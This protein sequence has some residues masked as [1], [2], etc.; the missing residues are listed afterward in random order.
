MITPIIRVITSIQ[1]MITQKKI[2]GIVLLICVISLASCEKNISVEVPH[3]ESAIVVEGYIEAG[4]HPFILLSNTLPFF[5]TISTNLLDQLQ[6][7]IQGATVTINNGNVIDTLQQVPGFGA[8]FSLNMV[9]EAGKTYALRIETDGKILT[10]STFIP[11]AVHLDSVWFKVDGNRDSLGYAWAHLTD[12]DTLGNCYRWFAQRINHYTY[13]DDAGKEKDTLF[14]APRGS[15]F[16]DKFINARSFDFA[17]NRG[18]YPNS[19]K[20]DDNNDERGFYKT[21]D[22]IIIKFCTIDRAHFEFWRTEETQVGNNGNPFGSPA[23]VT[24]NII[25]GLGIWGGYNATYDT[26]IAH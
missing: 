16:E 17:Y 14:I 9:G 24:S 7:T 1:K 10:A 22:T 15:V 25:G 21:G 5:G 4:K 13:G 8:Y 19:D 6:T 23:P 18:T 20:E 3:A 11:A 26:I 2:G 12:P